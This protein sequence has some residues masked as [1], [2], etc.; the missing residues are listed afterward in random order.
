MPPRK[1]PKEDFVAQVVRDIVRKRGYVDTQ[2][3]LRY[4]VEKRLKKF[5]LGF[6][7]SSGR[8]KK[9][10]LNIPEIRIKAKTK[11]SPKMKQINKCPACEAKIK[12]LYGTNLLNKRIHIGYA[13]KKCGFSTDLSSVV[14]MR[15]MFVW[16][17]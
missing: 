5:D 16:K 13:C 4:L 12:K 7:I 2:R 9:I 11:K 1:I 14:P 8:A 10:A 6:A 3:E 15:Y 17:S